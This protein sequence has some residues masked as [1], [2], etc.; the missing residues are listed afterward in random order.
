MPMTNSSSK[1][2]QVSGSTSKKQP[3]CFVN[4]GFKM[5]AIT[6]IELDFISK[7]NDGGKHLNIS[8]FCFSISAALLISILTCDFP[9]EFTKHSFIILF[10]LGI[11]VGFILLRCSNKKKSELNKTIDK[12]KKR[13]KADLFTN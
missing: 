3:K 12:V 11:L 1:R 4:G 6:D 10:I 9:T 13:R 2:K 8:I 5:L 7:W